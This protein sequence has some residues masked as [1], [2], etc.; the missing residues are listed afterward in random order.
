MRPG[1]GFYHWILCPA[2]GRAAQYGVAH[3]FAGKIDGGD[4]RIFIAGTAVVATVGG[5]SLTIP[6]F[7]TFFKGEESGQTG[8]SLTFGAGGESLSP[9]H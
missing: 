1:G 9:L 5:F 4:S 6:S 2:L 3:V 7:S 8:K